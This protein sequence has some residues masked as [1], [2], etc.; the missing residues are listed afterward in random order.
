MSRS[1]SG[2]ITPYA[3]VLPVNERV[4]APVD[5]SRLATLLRGQEG[6][7]CIP[8]PLGD[9]VGSELEDRWSGLET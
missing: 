3:A 7:G 5:T 2:S 8:G 9:T 1:G 4:G 6:I